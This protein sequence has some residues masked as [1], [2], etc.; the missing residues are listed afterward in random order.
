MILSAPWRHVA[1]NPES[2]QSQESQKTIE[3]KK[4]SEWNVGECK[5]G[6]PKKKETFFNL[7]QTITTTCL[8]QNK[9][10][11]QA[12]KFTVLGGAFSIYGPHAWKPRLRLAPVT[13]QGRS[14]GTSKSKEPVRE[15]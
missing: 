2:K 8:Y 4:L 7:H 1:G 12:D 5:I 3:E 13:E 10:L 11:G 15:R 6:G 14:K 9:R